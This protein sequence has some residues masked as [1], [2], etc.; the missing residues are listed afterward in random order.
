M[1]DEFLTGDS[2]LPVCM[3]TDD[4]NWQ[5]VFFEEHVGSYSSQQEDDE[6]IDAENDNN[7]DAAPKIK[8]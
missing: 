5:T 7:E 4:D 6:E 1:L 8:S 2:D 3:E